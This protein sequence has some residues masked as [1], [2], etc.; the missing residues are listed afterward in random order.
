MDPSSE[1]VDDEVVWKLSPLVGKGPRDPLQKGV[2]SQATISTTM[3][4][5]ELH[6]TTEGL[7]GWRSPN[8][9]IVS[10]TRERTELI[11][12]PLKNGAL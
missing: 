1:I 10:A 5:D 8:E 3:M 9:V 7:T 6:R 2:E 11:I 12:S 4:D